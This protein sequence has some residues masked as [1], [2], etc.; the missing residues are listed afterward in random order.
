MKLPIY[1]FSNHNRLFVYAWYLKTNKNETK[2]GQRYVFA[3]QDPYVECLK[4]IRES[5]DTRKDLFDDGTVVVAEIWDVTEIATKNGMMSNK[6]RFDDFLRK[7]IGCVKQSEVHNM[8]ADVLVEKVN[9][10]LRKEKQ[11]RPIVGLSTAQESDAIT[12]LKGI[13]EGKRRI[14]AELAARYGKTIWSSAVAVESG[15]PVIVVASYVL[16]SF[17]SFKNDIR[18]FQQFQDIEI[19]DS[20][21]EGYEELVTKFIEEGK[22]VMVFLSL[23]NGRNRTE[24]VKFLSSIEKQKLIFVDEADY[25]AHKQNQFDALQSM[26]KNDDVL[27]LMTGTNSDRAS[28]EWDIDLMIST[29]YFE[30]LVNKKEAISFAN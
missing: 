1:T 3:G 7:Q 29:T 4:R 20:Q 16:T 12:V 19:V 14:L 24:R 2:F 23:C 21:K 11:P 28:S 26:V 30:L 10:I 6:S 5:F 8:S 15:I 27:I 17:T 22:Q 9:D 25:G 18:K 13:K